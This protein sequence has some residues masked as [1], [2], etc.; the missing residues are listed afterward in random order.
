LLPW[1]LAGSLWYARNYATFGQVK[2]V[3][4]E[5]ELLLDR[6]SAMIG[7]L[8]GVDVAAGRLLY[9][10]YL[11]PGPVT[12]STH[13]RFYLDR[14]ALFAKITMLSFV[15]LFAQ[16]AQ[17]HLPFYFP[18]YPADRKPLTR[19]V[20]AGDFQAVLSELRSH[21]LANNL[22]F[23]GLIG[24]IV[25]LLAGALLSVRYLGGQSPPLQAFLVIVGLIFVY[26]AMVNGIVGGAAR[27]RLPLSPYLAILAGYGF[28]R[29]LVRRRAGYL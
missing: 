22:I 15:T 27:Y 4:Q 13:I 3:G 23:A 19:L 12:T 6:T 14:P 29:T 2:F 26:V 1:I 28:A 17:W 9:P 5:A 16:P 20:L 8:E 24:H 7:D 25:V 10:K 21:G 18:D 11:G